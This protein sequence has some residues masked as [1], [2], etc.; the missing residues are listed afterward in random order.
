VLPPNDQDPITEI[1]RLA[2][3]RGL[4]I[5]QNSQPAE[6]D[7]R[8]VNVKSPGARETLQRTATK[9]VCRDVPAKDQDASRAP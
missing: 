4:A 1:L 3:R 7:T 8:P 6:Q 9:S 5:R 2:F